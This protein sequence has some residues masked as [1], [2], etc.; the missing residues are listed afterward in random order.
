VRKIT[1]RRLGAAWIVIGC[2]V[3]LAGGGGCGGRSVNQVDDAREGDAGDPSTGGTAGS[4]TGAS[5]GGTGGTGGT[6]A[7]TGGNTGEPSDE[8]GG[9]R[10]FRG[11]CERSGNATVT[12]SYWGGYEEFYIWSEE[13]VLN[14][15]LEE[16]ID[17]DLV[18]RIRFDVS[19]VGPAPAGCVDLDNA[20]CEWA[21]TVEY[22]NPQVQLDVNGACGRSEAGWDQAWVDAMVGS[23]ASYG[24]LYMWLGH[25]SVL[26][27]YSEA[28]GEWID[29]A[30][31]FWDEM[32]GEFNYRLRLG[33][34]RY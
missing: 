14:G 12:S 17:D 11:I 4:S 33:Y 9:E 27:T 10:A 13:A 2:G 26:M 16:P 19:L 5:S 6:G 25:D 3:S 7:S 8:P 31:A 30:R 34:C 22:S 21:H 28:T 23:R 18:C 32:T 29:F 1:K 20:P 15:P 24:Y